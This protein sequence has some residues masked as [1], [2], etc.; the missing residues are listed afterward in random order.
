MLGAV[1]VRQTKLATVAMRLGANCCGTLLCAMRKT[2]TPTKQAAFAQPQIT[3]LGTSAWQRVRFLRKGD[4]RG[5]YPCSQFGRRKRQAAP[6]G[7]RWVP[8]SG[9]E[10]KNEISEF[11]R[12]SE[13]QI[14][15]IW[16]VKTPR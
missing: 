16:A 1:G 9:G 2:V 15:R 10:V 12:L 14:S 13:F 5:R 11:H 7:A 6:A 4:L 8:G 3:D